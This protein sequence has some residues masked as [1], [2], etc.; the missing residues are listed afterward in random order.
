MDRPNPN[1]PIPPLLLAKPS[2]Y[3]HSDPLLKRL[4]L[5]DAQ[6]QPIENIRREFERK[7]VVVFFI[8]SVEGSGEPYQPGLQPSS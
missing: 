3:T 2:I 6:G 7:Q 4:R 5:E 1:E 8:G